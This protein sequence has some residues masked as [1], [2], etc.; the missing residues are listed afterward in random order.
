MVFEK[1]FTERN[2]IFQMKLTT[3]I[4]IISSIIGSTLT[5]LGFW[6]YHML[7]S[8]NVVNLILSLY[9]GNMFYIFIPLCCEH[10]DIDE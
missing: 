1:Y 10:I 5:I 6:Y 3:K 7:N 8:E 4:S 9:V 2:N